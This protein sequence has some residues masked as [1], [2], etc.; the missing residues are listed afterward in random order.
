MRL[1]KSGIGGH[2]G[3]SSSGFLR[4]PI[5]KAFNRIWCFSIE[6]WSGVDNLQLREFEITVSCAQQLSTEQPSYWNRYEWSHHISHP[7]LYPLYRFD[8]PRPRLC[9]CGTKKR[10]TPRATNWAYIA[11]GLSCGI[12][13]Y[14][15]LSLTGISYPVHQHPTLFALMQLVGGSYHCISAFG[16]LCAT[17]QLI[18]H[19]E[20]DTSIRWSDSEFF[21]Q[22]SGIFK[23]L[24]GTN[25][26][27]SSWR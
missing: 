6:N 9:T 7:R 13:L 20:A 17:W 16:A 22:T 25:I 12:L 10:N 1:I 26:F 23:R 14:L 3:C 21:G 4:S 2:R 18:S 15:L 27:K 8:E 19:H 5:S 11:F 24:C